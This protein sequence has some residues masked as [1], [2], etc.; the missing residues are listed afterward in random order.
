LIREEEQEEM[1][2]E[3]HE[4]K[5]KPK[6]KFVV[7]LLNVRG[8]IT[9]V[10]SKGKADS[11]NSHS[12]KSFRTG[13]KFEKASSLEKKDELATSSSKNKKEETQQ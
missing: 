5:K 10:R 12:Y 9:R 3:R 6:S 8:F 13:F 11:K 4:I 2:Q 1:N 7:V